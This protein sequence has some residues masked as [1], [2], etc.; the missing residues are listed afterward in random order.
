MLNPHLELRAAGV[1]SGLGLVARVPIMAGQ[2]IWQ[3]DPAFA[4]LNAEQR[5]MLRQSGNTDY[6][7]QVGADL[8]ARNSREEYCMNHSCNPNCYEKNGRIYAIRDISVDEEVTYDYSLTEIDLNFEFRCE[9]RSFLCRIMV[10]NL[11]YLDTELMARS[12]GWASEHA[13]VAAERASERERAFYALFR[14][15]LLLKS[16]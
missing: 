15:G 10:S 1:I 11:D 8:Y 13:Q 9:C 7:S 3:P 2:L 12:K 4:L 6:Y 16:N 5:K 14:R